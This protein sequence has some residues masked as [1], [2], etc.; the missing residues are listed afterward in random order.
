VAKASHHRSR[1]NAGFSPSGTK[2]NIAGY[3]GSAHAPPIKG[4]R[5]DRSSV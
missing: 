2:R 1:E 5:A 3:I 4:N